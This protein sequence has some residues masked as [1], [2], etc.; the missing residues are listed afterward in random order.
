MVKVIKMKSIIILKIIYIDITHTHNVPTELKPLTHRMKRM[1]RPWG[2]F[3]E[4]RQLHSVT[5][6]ST[7]LVIANIP[8][9]GY[10]R[11]C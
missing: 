1:Y 9:L 7:S 8:G 6:G 2:F 5:V 4:S 10:R 11:A 3:R